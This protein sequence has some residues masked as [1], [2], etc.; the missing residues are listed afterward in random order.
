M[1]AFMCLVTRLIGFC[2][3]FVSNMKIALNGDSLAEQ[4]CILLLILGIVIFLEYQ[5]FNSCKKG[6]I[7]F[8]GTIYSNEGFKFYSAQLSY[9][10]I[11]GFI[12]SYIVLVLVI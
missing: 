7:Y 4:A 6:E 1:G 12:I 8:R 3:P 11:S 10:F 5:L 2:F 9:S